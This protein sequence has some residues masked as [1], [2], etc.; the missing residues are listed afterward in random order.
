MSGGIISDNTVTGYRGGGV[1]VNGS[2]GSAGSFT[3]TGGT[4]SGNSITAGWGGGVGIYGGSFTMTGGTINGNSGD[5]GG[6]VCAYGNANFTMTGGT[7]SGNTGSDGGG[8]CVYTDGSSFTMTGGTISGNKGYYG[9]GVSLNNTTSSFIMTGGII[10]GNI[11]TSP[12]D[13]STPVGG[14]VYIRQGNFSKSGGGIIYGKET[15]S[16]NW[17]QAKQDTLGHAVYCDNGSKRRN[18]TLYAG[19]NI[20]TGD[21]TVNR[22][23]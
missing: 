12:L 2:G 9:G 18:N 22:D 15:G 16:P 13:N 6:G 8:V 14:G 10:S 17:N 20:S 19:D 11:A 23:N 5:Y 7:I 3:M 4:I 1:F 21:L